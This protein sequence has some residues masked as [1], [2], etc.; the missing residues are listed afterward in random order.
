MN[1]KEKKNHVENIIKNNNVFDDLLEL[2]RDV[3]NFR[4]DLNDN[5][6]TIH[7]HVIHCLEVD[8]ANFTRYRV[9]I[10]KPGTEIISMNDSWTEKL[11]YQSID[12]STAIQT[13]KLIRKMTYDHFLSLIDD[14]WT[15]YSFFYDKYG[16]LNF[17]VFVPV[18]YRHPVG[19]R[20]FIDRNIKLWKEVSK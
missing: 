14:D 20:E 10:V 7:E 19:H 5:P 8:I 6:W 13:I 2:D 3:L 9:G 18:F 12:L 15:K 4:P 16:D 11:N 1:R 17:E